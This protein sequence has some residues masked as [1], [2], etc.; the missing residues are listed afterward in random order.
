MTCFELCVKSLVHN[1][2]G[3][4]CHH[5]FDIVSL[6]FLKAQKFIVTQLSTMNSHND[7][8]TCHK[9]HLSQRDKKRKQIRE[10]LMSESKKAREKE[11]DDDCSENLNE[12]E[13]GE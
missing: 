9:V 4:E 3:A 11:R 10:Q 1:V 12:N 2:T 13:S 8:L 7:S 6:L 5:F